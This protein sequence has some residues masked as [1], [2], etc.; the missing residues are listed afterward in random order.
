MILEIV[1]GDISKLIIQLY[2][3]FLA[4]SIV[5]LAIG[6]DLYF[7]IQKSRKAGLYTHSYGLRQTSKKTVQYLAL[8]SFLLFIDV[9]NPFWIYFLYQPMPLFSIFGAIVLTY[10]EYKSVREKSDQKFR[11]EF[12]NNTKE[13]L[14]FIKDNKEFFKDLTKNK[15]DENN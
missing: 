9:L 14:K 7:G 4:W 12:E 8:M 2:V 1:T 6:I 11:S 3:V 5:I 10:T 13:I 15:P